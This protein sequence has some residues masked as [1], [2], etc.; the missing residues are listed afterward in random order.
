MYEYA[1]FCKCS[2]DPLFQIQGVVLWYE[3]DQEKRSYKCLELKGRES[4][5]RIFGEHV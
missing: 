5:C 4:N 3:E 1:K 2:W